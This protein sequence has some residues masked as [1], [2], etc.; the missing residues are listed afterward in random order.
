MAEKK[1]SVIINKAFV[2]RK[3]KVK[4]MIKSTCF[5][6]LILAAL[7]PKIYAQSYDF[8][9]SKDGSGNFTTIQEAINSVPDLRLNRTRIFIKPGVYKEKLTL[10]STKTNV[11]F[12]GEDVKKTILTYDDY[13]SKKNCFGENIG[14]SRGWL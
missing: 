1:K 8:T 10:P 9:V 3:S 5:V 13:A 2:T 11:S 12:I 6:F 7:S 14:T 4:N